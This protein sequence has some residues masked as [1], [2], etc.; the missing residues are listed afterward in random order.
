MGCGASAKQN[1]DGTSTSDLRI[2][3]GLS[4]DLSV[5]DLTGK[6]RDSEKGCNNSFDLQ[7]AATYV[8]ISA[9]VYADGAY[10]ASSKA[11]VGSLKQGLGGVSPTLRY[12][13]GGLKRD[14]VLE[15]D[16]ALCLVALDSKFDK[17]W[18]DGSGE[19]PGSMRDGLI[20]Y[21]DGKYDTQAIISLR[22]KK[23][24]VV[25]SFRGTEFSSDPSVLVRDVMTDA[26]ADRVSYPGGGKVHHGVYSALGTVE[27][28]IVDTVKELL[29]DTGAY[30]HVTVIGHSLG[31]GLAVLCAMALANQIPNAVV[32]VYTYGGMAVGC[33]KF[34]ERF[35]KKVRA[36]WRVVNDQ[37][38]IPTLM[39]GRV[40]GYAHVG[41][42]VHIN[43]AGLWFDCENKVRDGVGGRLSCFTD[44]LIS[45]YRRL[46]DL[47]SAI[48]CEQN[49]DPAIM[50]ALQEAWEIYLTSAEQNQMVLT[51][52]GTRQGSVRCQQVSA[53]NQLGLHRILN[54][55]LGIPEA[56]LRLVQPE[57]LRLFWWYGASEIDWSIFV[58]A[59]YSLY[60]AAD[61]DTRK[62]RQNKARWHQIFRHF[63]SDMDEFL[64]QKEF[65]AM[66]LEIGQQGDMTHEQFLAEIKKD[67]KSIDV[68]IDNE[69][70][71]SEFML[72]ERTHAKHEHQKHVFNCSVSTVERLIAKSQPVA[73]GPSSALGTPPAKTT[74]PDH[75]GPGSGDP[76]SLNANSPPEANKV[77][78]APLPAPSDLPGVVS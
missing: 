42:D 17:T 65:T 58:I 54:Q 45:N 6:K 26:L 63:D 8:E 14:K 30:D 48:V 71:F 46:L 60:L 12:W 3:D 68:N 47:F 34:K 56:D 55:K 53:P 10:W 29:K 9:M 16:N 27:K 41:H 7:R 52:K 24:E 22:P 40:M 11:G 72:W 49:R 31:G 25:V 32:D 74:P 4:S 38:I 67:F 1:H 21:R 75:T 15:E 59:V 69:L 77:G 23:R 33:P 39:V 35:D 43:E 44:H 5:L 73:A 70:S 62:W 51:V 13:C 78:L 2:V 28:V 61:V 19:P 50:L 64:D 57:M 18:G 36:C 37:D 66:M 20:H 76:L